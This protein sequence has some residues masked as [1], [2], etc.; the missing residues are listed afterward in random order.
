MTDYRIIVL[1]GGC[2]P[3]A[4]VSRTSGQALAEAF[5][6]YH[7]TI[8]ITLAEDA[9]PENFDPKNAIIFP[10]LHGGFGENGNL[11][12]Q[13]DRAGITYA[14]SDATASRLCMDKPSAKAIA[15]SQGF[16]V[17]KEVVF[18]SI[19]KPT[20]AELIATVGLPL[21]LKPADSG[22]ALGLQLPET[23]EALARC[24]PNLPQG[25]WLAES[26]ISGREVTIGWLEGECLPIVEIRPS[27]GV[28]DFSHKYTPGSTQYLCPAPLTQSESDHL[29]R[30]AQAT[31]S[32]AG[33]RDFAR[34]DAILD[35]MGEA[36]F[37][38]INTLPGMT[39][40]S[41]L[42]K[43]AAAA[44]WNFDALAQRLLAPA[45]RRHTTVK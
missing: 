22:S 29:H 31:F 5:G 33:V 20:P 15:Q 42:P 43:A 39:P 2:S 12:A 45:K 32:A 14:G 8:L 11:Q 40:T 17:A 35:P 36:W 21:V 13:L 25:R 18:E 30:L 6:K 24:L 38:E 3:E 16:R 7:E 41:L 4:E 23:A 27:G 26:K 28:Y 37:L 34:L 1:C 19:D 10:A 44:G 9:L